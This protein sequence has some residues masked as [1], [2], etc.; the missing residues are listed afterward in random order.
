M[1]KYVT[2]GN[3]L[4]YRNKICRY[5]RFIATL[6]LMTKNVMQCNQVKGKK[7]TFILTLNTYECTHNYFF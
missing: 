5:F 2:L 3:T 1:L 6:N 7:K 4:Q